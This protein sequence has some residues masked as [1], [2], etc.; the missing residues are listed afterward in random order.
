M[1]GEQDGISYIPANALGSPPRVRGTGAPSKNDNVLPRITPACAGNSSLFAVSGTDLK[2]HPRVCGEQCVMPI[3]GRLIVGSPPRV[4]GT[5]F[6]FS[7]PSCLHRITPACAGNRQ[8]PAFYFH[9]IIGSPPRVRGTVPI[10]QNWENYIGITPAC[11]G[12]RRTIAGLRH[13]DG[14]HPRVCGEQLRTR[15]PTSDFMGSPPR[16][17]GTGLPRSASSSCSRITPACAG[18]RSWASWSR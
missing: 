14:D 11:A 12:N 9:P 2:D 18:N 5:G 8:R 3:I 1:C 7:V 10:C 4:R 15:I 13:N 6:D 16:V 17:R